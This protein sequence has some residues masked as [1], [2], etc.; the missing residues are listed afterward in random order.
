MAG[1]RV[2]I[3]GVEYHELV[4]GCVDEGCADYVRCGRGSGANNIEVTKP[5]GEWVSEVTEYGRST[6]SLFRAGGEEGV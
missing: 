2:L 4:R 1:V 3:G 6:V 5:R